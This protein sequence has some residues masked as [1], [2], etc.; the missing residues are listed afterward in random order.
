MRCLPLLFALIFAVPVAA[1]DGDFVLAKREGHQWFRGNMH[2]HSLWSDG[3]DYPEMIARWY[4]DRGYQFLVFT[5]HNV[6]HTGERWIDVNRN[7]AGQPA[8]DKLR[9]AFGDWTQTREVDGRQEV[10]LK[11]FDEVFER[12]ATPGEFLLIQ[13][14]EITDRFK[15]AP[16]HLCATNLS[17]L[18]PP[19]HG[20][21]VQDV[22]QQNI[23]A[24]VARRERTGQKTLVH[25]NH[26]NFGWAVTA[27]QLMHVVGENFFEVYN[28]HPSVRN[29]GDATHASTERMWDIINTW[30]L[31][32]LD[33]PFLYGLATDD[34]HN[35]HRQQSGKGSQPGRG[36]VVVLAEKLDPDSLVDALEAGHFYSSSGVELQSVRFESGRLSVMVKP[37]EGVDY[38]IQFIGTKKDFDDTTTPASDDE[39]KATGL[40][41][42]YSQQVGQI[43]SEVKGT[44]ASYQVTKDDLY[45]RAVVTSSRPHPNPAEAGEWE[46]AWIQPVRLAR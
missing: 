3:D 13:G 24:A 14:E 36:W 39:A 15:N 28:G 21:S 43:L 44:S 9:A 18:L 10:R 40:T 5:D 26:P 30:R 32:K 31:A 2:T 46:R 33:L 6:L 11:T 4:R 37:A 12:L 16:I 22:M 7:R 34:G 42:V 1:D 19:M 8:L 27:E 29:L 25:L 20:E 17:E 41:R 23:N 45:V 35:Y 38:T